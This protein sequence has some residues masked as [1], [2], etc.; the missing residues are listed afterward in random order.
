MISIFIVLIDPRIRFAMKVTFT[1]SSDHSWARPYLLQTDLY[2][3]EAAAY[4]LF[5]HSFAYH[6]NFVNL[7][8]IVQVNFVRPI[9]TSLSS[10]S[11][12]KTAFD[13]VHFP[14]FQFTLESTAICFVK[15]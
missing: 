7:A 13:I 6:L 11:I 14:L 3:K 15:S 1:K 8:S 5:F 10:I 4:S 2:L 9:S 12:I